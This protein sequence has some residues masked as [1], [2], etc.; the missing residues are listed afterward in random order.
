M[1]ETNKGS[2]NLQVRSDG[3]KPSDVSELLDALNS[4]HCPDCENEK[5]LLGPEGGLTQNIK[6]S[7]CGNR[8]NY[9]PPCF[10]APHGIA[11]RI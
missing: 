10:L 1:C 8:F 7:K 11:E 5:F 6:C 3:H 9:C 2:G 4:G